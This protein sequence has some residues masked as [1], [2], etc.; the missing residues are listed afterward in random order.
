MK[1]RDARLTGTPEYYLRDVDISLNPDPGT[2]QQ[3]NIGVALE[4]EN[5]EIF[6]DAPAFRCDGKLEVTLTIHP[7]GEAEEA[8]PT[9]YGEIEAKFDLLLEPE[10]AESEADEAEWVD[11]VGSHIDTWED[12]GYTSVS[13]EFQTELESEI[14][15][16]IFVPLNDL[17][18]NQFRGIVPRVIFRPPP[19]EREE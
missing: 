15:S 17:I 14:F 19:E 9:D 5:P 7:S 11:M 3:G 10:A 16:E 6:E 12:S 1:S 8:E 2:T 18:E 4:M 13:E